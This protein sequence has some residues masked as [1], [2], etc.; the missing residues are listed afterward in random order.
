[1]EFGAATATLTKKLSNSYGVSRQSAYEGVLTAPVKFRAHGLPSRFEDYCEIF[2]GS[3]H[4]LDSSIPIL[5]VPGLNE[6]KILD[7]IRGS[8]P[9]Y[10]KV[11]GGFGNLDAAV[12]YEELLAEPKRKN[13]F[14][15]EA[16]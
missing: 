2:G 13:S 8:K 5:E 16:R 4:S 7:D 12:P 15:K 6:R 11:F 10:S 3:E 14:S 9:D 1:M